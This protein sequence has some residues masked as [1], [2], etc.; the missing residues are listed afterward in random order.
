VASHLV[1]YMYLLLFGGGGGELHP[2]SEDMPTKASTS[3]ASAFIFAHTA[4][5]KQDAI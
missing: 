3:V 5:Q 2:P 1:S 4:S